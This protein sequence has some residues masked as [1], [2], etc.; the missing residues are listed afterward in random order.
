MPTPANRTARLE[1]RIR[2]LERELYDDDYDR[3][4]DRRRRRRTRDGYGR[5]RRGRGR[6]RGYGVDFEDV[7][8]DF[9]DVADRKLDELARI[10]TGVFRA[11]L[12]GFRAVAEGT[13]EFAE[14]T[15]ERSIPERDEDPV[16]VLTRL[17]GHKSSGVARGFDR[18]LDAPS[19]IAERYRRAWTEEEGG[20]R[21]RRISG[22]T[23]GRR[24]TGVRRRR[25]VGGGEDY[26]RWSLQ[27]LYDR[28]A[29]L[30]IDDFRD[31]SRDELIDELREE[32]PRYDDW[33][34]SDL[35]LRAADLNIEGRA[36]MSRDELIAELRHR[37]SRGR[38]ARTELEERRVDREPERLSRTELERR[39]EKVGVED[40]GSRTDAQ[41]AEAVSAGRPPL[42]DMTKEELT[43]RARELDIEGRSTMTREELIQA[44][45]RH[46]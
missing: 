41:L 26:E 28:A 10:V 35:Y 2:D 40:P 17:P 5:R 22:R 25:G 34:E 12:E 46:E 24:E 21:R 43:E 36:D 7:R 23:R 16:D 3:D 6:G 32:Q 33:S 29:E 18:T 20:R 44:I 8:D 39:A 30:G 9:A 11:T 15:I 31:M 27:E 19:R 1:A 37:E 38:P 13:S 14:D 42:E 45:R 4:D